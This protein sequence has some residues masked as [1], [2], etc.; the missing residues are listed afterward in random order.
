MKQMKR[1]WDEVVALTLR[2]HPMFTQVDARQHGRQRAGRLFLTGLFVVIVML[3]GFL[4]YSS[5]WLGWRPPGPGPDVALTGTTSSTSSSTTTSTATSTLPSE[6]P[7][8]STSTLPSMALDAT[9]ST[10]SSPLDT[11]TSTMSVGGPTP[12]TTAV[13]QAGGGPDRIPKGLGHTLGDFLRALAT[14]A[15]SLD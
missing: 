3:A 11:T 5:V 4:V 15:D 12:S 10:P 2:R 7:N 1:I 13:A 6:A 9:S 14:T 8:T